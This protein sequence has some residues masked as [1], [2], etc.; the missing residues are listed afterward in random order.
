[1]AAADFSA[2]E[3]KLRLQTNYAANSPICLACIEKTVTRMPVSPEST[4]RRTFSRLLDT[5]LIE[6]AVRLHILFFG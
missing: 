3:S 4:I 2:I 6:F 5:Q 1:V